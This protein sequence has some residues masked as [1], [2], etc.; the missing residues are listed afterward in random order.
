[1]PRPPERDLLSAWTPVT[2]KEGGVVR[3]TT[4]V[5]EAA[6]PSDA[7][8]DLEVPD[9]GWCSVADVG[10]HFKQL[11]KVLSSS[12]REDLAQHLNGLRLEH[13]AFLDQLQPQLEES[14]RI[15]QELQQLLQVGGANGVAPRPQRVN[16]NTRHSYGGPR[17]NSTNKYVSQEEDEGDCHKAVTMRRSA[18]QATEA[19]KP[20]I[21]PS[22]L[23]RRIR[24]L[25][26]IDSHCEHDN[27]KD[28]DKELRK[29]ESSGDFG[30]VSSITLAT[31]N[32]D[33]LYSKFVRMVTS[34]RFELIIG[35]FIMVN[36]I[37]MALDAQLHGETVGSDLNYPRCT[38][39]PEWQKL[40]LEAV[41]EMLLWVFVLELVFKTIALRIRLIIGSNRYWN[42]LDIIV[43]VTGV[44]DRFEI[45]DFGLDPMILRLLRLIKLTRF[46]K[47]FKTLGPSLQT[48]MLILKSV[49]ASQR[50][51]FWSML[52]L[53]I[54]Q[55]IV[56]MLVY[57]LVRGFMEEENKDLVVRQNIFKYWGT[58]T[59][60]QIT[61]FE[62]THVNH[63]N[64]VRLLADHVSEWWAWFF[65]LYRCT[66][67]FAFLSVIR[68]VFIQA[69]LKVAERDRELLLHNKRQAS[70]EL[71][72]K[73][74][75]VFHILFGESANDDFK[76]SRIQ[77]LQTFRQDMA[78][79]WMSALDIDISHPEG[80]FALM[81]LDGDG[82]ISVKEFIYVADKVRGPAQTIDLYYLQ[83]HVERI[84]A[85]LELLH[86]ELTHMLD[87][88]SHQV[89]ESSQMHAA[90]DQAEQADKDITCC[91]EPCT[92]TASNAVQCYEEPCS[93]TG[94]LC[95]GVMDMLSR[96]IGAVQL[97]DNIKNREMGAVQLGEFIDG[98]V[99]AQRSVAAVETK[100]KTV[101][102]I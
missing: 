9:S 12:L 31:S 8:D 76:I 10:S 4:P 35:G 66:I 18:S 44:I 94:G 85:D 48:M 58:F 89:K 24:S 20:G 49:R 23:A 33:T 75:D 81:D 11:Q 57:Q 28:V 17:R 54:I 43:V 78:K 56:G 1:M 62:I 27:D 63:A 16:D 42:A 96:E 36:T 41:N 82:W 6:E 65:I 40:F 90:F 52:L 13:Q 68:A 69:T 91:E 22:F 71:H 14:L 39:P 74:H 99:E 15:G 87:R 95:N 2:A 80:L 26:D 86:P 45:V 100:T 73:L 25:E 72:Q 61:M 30:R 21:S 101:A 32:R 53:F 55:Y 7:P 19:G 34:D 38:V 93:P 67:A 47:L 60:S 84:E 64:A 79:V 37:T 77:F 102:E 50:T 29:L 97:G 70:K 46:V 59:K 92:P 3:H 88:Y 5:V 51:L 98:P 83:T